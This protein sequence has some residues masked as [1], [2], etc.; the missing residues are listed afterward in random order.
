MA[1][2][3]VWL[4]IFLAALNAVLSV[5]DMQPHVAAQKASAIADESM[6]HLHPDLI[7]TADSSAQQSTSQPGQQQQATAQPQ[8]TSQPGQA[9][10]TPDEIAKA[11]ELLSRVPNQSNG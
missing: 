7:K 5:T 2:A 1:K 3:E 4:K 8:P 6:S 10:P 9:A 11:R